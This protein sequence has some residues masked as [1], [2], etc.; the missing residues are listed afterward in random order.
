MTLV[1]LAP[2]LHSPPPNSPRQLAL[3]A[4][5]PQSDRMAD[6][7]NSTVVDV[8]LLA[9]GSNVTSAMDAIHAKLEKA[10][11]AVNKITASA[12]VGSKKF[13]ANLNRTVKNLQ[14]VMSQISTLEK[15][16]YAGAGGV[17]QLNQAQQFRSEEH[18]S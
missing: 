12:D 3:A 1:F 8:E 11:A 4:A 2:F 16:M 14:Q 17:R 5:G 9:Q 15:S 18:T 13:E 6:P 7:T 10:L